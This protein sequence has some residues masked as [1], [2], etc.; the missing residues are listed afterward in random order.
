MFLKK[1]T[2]ISA[3]YKWV[4][5]SKCLLQEDALFY[6][7]CLRGMMIAEWK[8]LELQSMTPFI[9]RLKEHKMTACNGEDKN[10]KGKDY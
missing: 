2:F 3:L 4:Q 1:K 8:P 7:V 5:H 9:Y 10:I 6:Q